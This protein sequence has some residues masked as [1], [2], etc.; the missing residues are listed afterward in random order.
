MTR[1]CLRCVVLVAPLLLL[2]NA[3]GTSAAPSGDDAYER[4][5][6]TSRDFRPVKQDKDWCYAAFPAW[7]YMPWT[8]RWTIGY[9]DAAGAWSRAHGYNGAFVDRGDIHAESSPTGRLDWIDKFKL[10]FYVDHLASKGSL[11]LWDGGDLK[12]H[13]SELHGDGV[14]PVPLNAA[15]AQTLQKL[16]S[17]HVAAVKKLPLRAAYALDDETSWGHFIHPCMW[18]VTDDEAAYPAW[19]KEIYGPAAAPHRDRWVTYDDIRPSLRTW[20]V[21]TFDASPLMDQWTFND[22]YWNNFLGDLVEYSNGVD[23]HTPCGIVGGQCPDAFGGF[24]YAKLMRKVQFIEAYNIGSSQAIIRSFNP[25]NAIPSVTSHFH[26]SVADDVWQTWYYLAHGN[27]GFIGWVNGWFDGDKPKPW[28]DEVAPTYL[29]AGNKIGPLLAGAEWVHD[30]VAI[31]YS[32]ASIQLGWILD[33]EAHG[34]TWT[35]RNGDERLGASH[36]VRH[37]WENMLRDAGLQY[38]FLSYAD[39]VQHGVPPQY[40]VLILPACLCLSDAEARQIEAFCKAGGTVVADYLPGLW[41]QHGKGRPAGGA[42]DAMFGVR[43]DPSLRAADLFGGTLWCEVNQEANFNWKTYRE[44]LTNKNTCL[45]STGGFNK[46]V[47]AMPT[48]TVRRHGQ[49]TAV[50]MNL[51]PQWYNAF[52]DAGHEA[53]LKRDVFVRHVAAGGA[54][55]WVELAGAGEAEH[56]YEITYWSKEGRTI[57]CLCLNPEVIG[58][59]VGGGN[60]AGL[61]TQ[62]LPITLSFANGVAGVRDERTEKE[63]GAGKQF[64]LDWRTNE[65]VILSFAGSPPR[66][67]TPHAQ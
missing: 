35:S 54:K 12:P 32:H 17:Q 16:I 27:R 63:L 50:L 26:Q 1:L 55:R 62:I 29:E 31:Y 8:A 21:G 14:R 6:K 37:A 43:H 59:Q 67:A 48:E 61:K 52:R 66:E 36:M 33:A 25:R 22:S 5:V 53:A 23:P 40:K 7:T 47:R 19:L 2:T 64:R 41:D 58:S 45:Q 13:L 56:G 39:V 46:A 10:R 51:S 28:H 57:V 65:A 15:L 3:A 60:A 4:Y 18:R 24:D 38:D 34:K 20:T 30:G 49:G 11:H 9:T 44:F 42:L